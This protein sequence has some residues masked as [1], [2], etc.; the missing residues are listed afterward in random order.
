MLIPLSFKPFVPI[1]GGGKLVPSICLA[2]GESPFQIGL[3]LMGFLSRI[4]PIS[5]P[6][7]DC[8]AVIKIQHFLEPMPF[9]SIIGGITFG[10]FAH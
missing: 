10:V 3:P 6:I 1:I 5:R 2:M 4:R 9:S 8:L 7:T